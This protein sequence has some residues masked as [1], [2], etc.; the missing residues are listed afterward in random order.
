M[1]AYYE[2]VISGTVL[3]G[4]LISLKIHTSTILANVVRFT[5]QT[6]FLFFIF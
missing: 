2:F 3:I 5:I 4:I 1:N 6:T